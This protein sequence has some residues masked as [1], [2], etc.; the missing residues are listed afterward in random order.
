M[1]SE[2]KFEGEKEKMESLGKRKTA[3]RK[4]SI[5]SLILDAL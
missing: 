1:G 5:A 3:L 2:H 4:K